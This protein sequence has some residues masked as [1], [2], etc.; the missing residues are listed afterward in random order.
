MFYRIFIVAMNVKQKILSI[1][2]VFTASLGAISF[3]AQPAMAAKCGDTE[4]SIIGGDICAGVN[5]KSSDVR[6]NA[7]WKLLLLALN[8]LTAGVGIAA[9]GGI[10]WGSFLYVTA[11]DKAA[12]TQ[13]AISII[14]NVVI[15]LISYAAM[16]LLLNFLIP[17]GIF[18]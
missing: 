1:V 16:Y 12:Q 15:G 6:Q 13:K 11:E 7:T 9:V 8:I 2:L 5:N 17:G 10:A 18:S 3:A 4:T 14:W